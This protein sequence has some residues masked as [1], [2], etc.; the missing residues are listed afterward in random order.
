MRKLLFIVAIAMSVS[1]MAQKVTRDVAVTPRIGMNV[2]SMT[3]M[4]GSTDPRYSLVAGVEVET[5]LNN[6]LTLSAGA[7]YSQQ[8]VCSDEGG[9][10]ST[11]KMDYINIPILLN[12]YLTKKFI[13]RVGVQPGIL[14][15][16]KIKVS[17]N[18][19][20]AEIDLDESMAKGGVQGSCQKNYVSVP[21][22]IAYD[23]NCGLEL[24]ARWNLP[25][26]AAIKAPG[27]DSKH[28]V[29]S[30]TLGYKF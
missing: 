30:L 18:G 22:G 23:L 10:D 1:T 16:D 12:V 25:L 21:I 24:D 15:N 9:F 4:D 2:C 13:F 20:S 28:K 5:K 3:E 7:L 29:F 14:V 11:I 27:E 8:G 19:I 26:S 6:S 17:S